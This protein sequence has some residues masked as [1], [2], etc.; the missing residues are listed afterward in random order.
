MHT[1]ILFVCH[2]RCVFYCLFPC[3]D[4]FG[5]LRYLF[6]GQC[7]GA[8]PEGFYHSKRNQ[9]KPCSDHCAI[10]LA[11]EHC[12]HCS[13]GH[14]LRKGKCVPLEC[15]TGGWRQ[16][17]SSF[18]C[19]S[20]RSSTRDSWF[21]SNMKKAPLT[22]LVT[23]KKKNVEKFITCFHF[24]SAPLRRGSTEFG[25][26]KLKKKLLI[27]KKNESQNSTNMQTKIFMRNTENRFS[28]RWI[29]CL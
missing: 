26:G 1:E 13:P 18:S 12:L 17:H 2:C 14:Q 8:C 3:S 19:L 10:C 9:C 11:E 20:K 16:S 24:H 6:Q 23:G 27:E 28:G 21:S 25:R 4:K 22:L 15:G 29:R 5:V 7:R